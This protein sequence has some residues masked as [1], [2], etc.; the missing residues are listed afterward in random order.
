MDE[1]TMDEKIRN[2][3]HGAGAEAFNSFPGIE[4]RVRHFSLDTHMDCG[5]SCSEIEDMLNSGWRFGHTIFNQHK[6]FVLIL[7]HRVK[8]EV[9]E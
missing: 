7:F 2:A 1:K 9:K 6:P 4:Y 3:F 5:K 8:E